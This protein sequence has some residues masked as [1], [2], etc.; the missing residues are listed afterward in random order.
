MR[1]AGCGLRAACLLLAACCSLLTT[2]YSLRA[3]RRAAREW[4]AIYRAAYGSLADCHR[5]SS[6]AE[7]KRITPTLLLI[8]AAVRRPSTRVRYRRLRCFCSDAFRAASASSPELQ[9]RWSTSAASPAR[10]VPQQRRQQPMAEQP[11]CSQILTLSVLTW[12]HAKPRR[13]ARGLKCWRPCCRS[14]QFI[15]AGARPRWQCPPPWS[16]NGCAAWDPS[17]SQPGTARGMPVHM[18]SAPMHTCN[19]RDGDLTI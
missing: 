9:R 5:T 7:R 13:A 15:I 11:L 8:T 4:S 1:S 2:H 12:S 3:A 6:G 16:L 17:P 18:I 10:T 14:R 19:G